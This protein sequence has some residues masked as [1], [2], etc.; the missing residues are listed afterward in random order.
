MPVE[1]EV[2]EEIKVELETE[3]LH[4]LQLAK[5]ALVGKIL[6]HKSLNRGAVKNI[7]QKAWGLPKELHITYVHGLPLQMM[8]TTNAAKIINRKPL[9]TGCWVPRKDLPK[10]EIF[11][12]Y[13][14]LQ[15]LCFNCG[16]LGHEQRDCKSDKAMESGWNHPRGTS[17]EEEGTTPVE[18]R[19]DQAKSPAIGQDVLPRDP[20]LSTITIKTQLHG[21]LLTPQKTP[22]PNIGLAQ[23]HSPALTIINLDQ[24]VIRPGLGPKDLNSL[25]I[26]PEFIGLQSPIV[27]IDY[28][29]P[30][31]H[32]YQGVHLSELDIQRCRKACAGDQRSWGIQ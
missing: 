4:S 24:R 15:G 16:I 29:S 7:I 26:V 6:S 30:K 27:I 2:T 10:S 5:R 8:N 31:Q 18:E 25:H 32:K 14:K 11:L 23:L 19:D 17:M 22:G 12:R 20:S 21:P 3:E 9:A 28:P 1:N 13:E